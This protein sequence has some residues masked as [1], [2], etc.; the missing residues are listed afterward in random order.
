MLD[1]LGAELNYISA[2]R[3]KKMTTQAPD[4]F[5]AEG[6]EWVVFS[7]E[8]YYRYV[9]SSRSL[10]FQTVMQSTAQYRGRTDTFSLRH[11]GQ[12]LLSE[13][14]VG[15]PAGAKWKDFVPVGAT[16]RDCE[17][18]ARAFPPTQ[19][20]D[21]LFSNNE[22]RLFGTVF[23][24]RNTDAPTFPLDYFEA[25]DC[26]RALIFRNGLLV[27]SLCDSEAVLFLHERKKRKKKKVWFLIAA[28]TLVVG[29]FYFRD[30]LFR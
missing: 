8:G 6:E 20:C 7:F 28:A 2:K 29:V 21:F 11:D 23:I 16:R 14:H 4:L 13:C 24:G 1:G 3:V 5:L 26:Q 10:G 9:P 30:V 15:L 25:F 22:I 27:R 17:T 12:L 19:A 18:N